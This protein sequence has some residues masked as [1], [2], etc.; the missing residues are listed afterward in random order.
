MGGYLLT[1]L[2]I[3]ILGVVIDVILPS[4]SISKYIS[5]I[6]AIVIMFVI[7]SPIL[8]LVKGG[9]NIRDYFTL[10]D[11]SLDEKLLYNINNSKF[12]ELE[13]QIEQE[14]TDNGYSNVNVDIQFN[15]ESTNVKILQVL[16]D[17]SNIVINGNGVNINKYVY[18]RQLIQSKLNVAK[19]VIVFC[20]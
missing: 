18:I 20:E 16:V 2:G 7:I 9:Y 14:L 3:V 8:S 10:Q 17:L 1:I 4:G 19:E 15:I 11:I 5:G 13:K 6:F 12:S